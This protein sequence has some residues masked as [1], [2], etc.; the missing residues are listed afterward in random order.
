M[1]LGFIKQVDAEKISVSLSPEDYV[2]MLSDGI[3]QAGEDASWLVEFLNRPPICDL[4]EYA[5]AIL[6]E[7]RANGKGSDD[8]S[9]LV[10][11]ISEI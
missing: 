9:V 8:M 4:K 6:N 2:I 1:P 7:A 3:S 10:M 5:E 11:R